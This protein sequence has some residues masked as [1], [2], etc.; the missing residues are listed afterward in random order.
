MNL[1]PFAGGQLGSRGL[2]EGALV[3]R[4]GVRGSQ[5][6]KVASHSSDGSLD[7]GVGDGRI[8]WCL[9]RGVGV[10]A[11]DQCMRSTTTAVDCMPHASALGVTVG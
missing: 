11:N 5:G 10:V 3:V 7:R 8:G 6:A 4:Q 9:R 1:P 2:G